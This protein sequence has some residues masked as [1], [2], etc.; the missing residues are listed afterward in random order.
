MKRVLKTGRV[1]YDRELFQDSWAMI[2]L[3]STIAPHPDGYLRPSEM[4]RLRRFLKRHSKRNILVVL[5]HNPI[6]L[7]SI[8]LDRMTVKNGAS[9]EKLIHRYPN[10]KGVLFGHVHQ[11]YERRRRG[12]LYM[13]TPSTCIQFI[14]RS[15]RMGLDRK[16]PGFRWLELWPNG[17]IRTGVERLL[18]SKQK[19]DYS[20]KRY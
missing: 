12:I 16:L 9:F 18:K 14:P 11:L 2:L 6:P 3:D 15:S 10:V 5:H 8:W 13:A 4:V 7:K 19:P 17:R 20:I 1:R